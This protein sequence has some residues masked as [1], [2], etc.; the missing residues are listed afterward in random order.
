[1]GEVNRGWLCHRQ[2]SWIDGYMDCMERTEDHDWGCWFI[3]QLAINHKLAE[4]SRYYST[5]G[6]PSNAKLPKGQ[7]L[8]TPPKS[9]L[10]EQLVFIRHNHFENRKI[11]EHITSAI[12]LDISLLR[13]PSW[14]HSV[15]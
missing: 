1:L 8:I 13:I 5:H 15:E 4:M 9:Q 14:Q 2:A 10:L 11:R 7:A 6:G 12:F 3:I